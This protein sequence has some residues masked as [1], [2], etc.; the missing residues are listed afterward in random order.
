VIFI[1]SCVGIVPNSSFML[2][3]I[4]LWFLLIVNFVRSLAKLNG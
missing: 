1:S 3:V 2:Y 4:N